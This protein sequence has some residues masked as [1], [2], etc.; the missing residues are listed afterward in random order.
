MKSCIFAEQPTANKE[1]SWWITRR[2]PS[3]S[4]HPRWYRG[5]GLNQGWLLLQ[6]KEVGRG[7]PGIL[8]F[9]NTLQDS[10]QTLF[11]PNHFG[12]LGQRSQPHP[13]LFPFTWGLLKQPLWASRVLL[14]SR[15]PASLGY[16]TQP[17]P[18]LN[19]PQRLGAARP[20]A[21]GT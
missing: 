18:L 21:T 11:T 2:I 16:K 14:T 20:T 4:P 6:P 3:G 19:P 15:L 17:I 10:W 8:G 12:M 9:F 7:E 5:G 1:C 13:T